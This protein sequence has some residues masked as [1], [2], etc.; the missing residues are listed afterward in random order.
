MYTA[1]RKFP[2]RPGSLAWSLPPSAI[3]LIM[4]LALVFVAPLLSQQPSPSVAQAARNAREHKAHSAPTPKIFTNDDLDAERSLPGDSALVRPPSAAEAEI[5]NPSSKECD[6]P[7]AE[8]L[9]MELQAAQQELDQVRSEL[10][11]QPTVISGNDLDLQYFKSGNSGLSVGAPPLSNVMPPI[12]ARVTAVELEQKIENLKNALVLACSS[13]EAASVQSKLDQAEQQ[14]SLLQRQFALD[15]D[16]YY[17]KPGY[18]QD[19]A[20]KARL[21]GEQQQIQ[22]L[23]S[24]VDRLKNELAA[25]NPPQ[26]VT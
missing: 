11:Y 14:L 7:Q 13:P 19:T 20:G 1:D 6:H 24:E 16:T 12:P 22:S 5:S 26:V 8:S 3:S 15:Q 4:F 23:Q 2:G 9:K 10:S 17:S 21:E 18:V 25:L